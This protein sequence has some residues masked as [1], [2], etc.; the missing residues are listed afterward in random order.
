MIAS[1][2]PPTRRFAWPL[3]FACVAKSMTDRVVAAVGHKPAPEKLRSLRRGLCK[4]RTRNMGHLRIVRSSLPSDAE[5]TA[6][7]DCLDAFQ[8]EFDYLFMILQR[9]G[10]GATEIDD[11]LQEIFVVLHRRWSTLDL[12]RPLR[13]WLFG[14]TFRLLRASRRRRAREVLG[15]EIELEDAAANPEESLQDRQSLNLLYVALDRVPA[16]RRS[17]VVMHDLEGVEIAEIARQLCMSKIGVYTRLY[18]GRRELASV[19]RRSWRA[20]VQP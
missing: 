12:T 17:V 20:D 13:P 6:E 16:A 4:T 19:L 2:P 10:A 18:K 11:L 15:T 8:R 9:M 5:E 3:A 7:T 14:V 1:T